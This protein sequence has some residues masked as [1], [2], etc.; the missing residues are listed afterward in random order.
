V[1]R[2]IAQHINDGPRALGFVFMLLRYGW[3]FVRLPAPLFLLLFLS[4]SFK[5]E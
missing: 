3:A 1:G 5:K 2:R 4:F